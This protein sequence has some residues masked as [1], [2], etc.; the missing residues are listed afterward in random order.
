[1]PIYELRHVLFCD[2]L[3]FSE[4][5][6]RGEIDPTLLLIA[7]SHLQRLVR[8]A[9]QEIDANEHDSET[10]RKYDYV[11]QPRA[12][13]FSDCIVIS[14]HAT[15][16]DAI[17]LCQASADIQCMLAQR[18]FLSRGSICTGLLHHRETSIFGP[19]FL[20][21][22]TREKATRWP[23]IEVSSETLRHFRNADNCEDQEIVKIRERQL[24]IAEQSDCVW[25]D[26]F[27]DLKFFAR[28]SES[29]PHPHVRPAIDA[30]RNVLTQG[31]SSQDESVFRKHEWMSRHY[32]RTL[33]QPGGW[34]APL[35]IPDFG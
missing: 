18:G 25:V 30:W 27:H 16:I 28:N 24:L 23:R 8:E 15:T 35:E 34:I 13:H 6:K 12:E 9:N 3:G 4:A 29:P 1:M 26:P 14:T 7:F 2:I 11:V 5:V 31:L 17:W 19:A 21:A 33:V 20:E 22:V 10:G 32:N